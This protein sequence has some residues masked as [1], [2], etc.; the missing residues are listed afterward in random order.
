MKRKIIMKPELD[1]SDV[2]VIGAAIDAFYK[3]VIIPNC[4]RRDRKTIRRAKDRLLLSL[5][6]TMDWERHLRVVLDNPTD[7]GQ[8]IAELFRECLKSI[9]ADDFIKSK[10]VLNAPDVDKMKSGLT[11]LPLVYEYMT[12]KDLETGVKLHKGV[13]DAE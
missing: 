10:K 2:A 6:F 5:M 11:K 7:N 4:P 12:G 8:K 3:S 1:E 9:A 13:I